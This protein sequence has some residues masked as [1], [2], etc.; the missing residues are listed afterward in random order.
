MFIWL[1]EGGKC[2]AQAKCCLYLEKL[3]ENDYRINVLKENVSSRPKYF[4]DLLNNWIKMLLIHLAK[5]GT[6]MRSSFFKLL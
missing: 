6:R 2:Q 3:H 5:R 4:V 1:G